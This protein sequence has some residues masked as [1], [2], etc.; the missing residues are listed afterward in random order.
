MTERSLSSKSFD[1]SGNDLD[2]L[3]NLFSVPM[4]SHCQRVAICSAII[5]GHVDKPLYPSGV[6]TREK[7]EVLLHL[8]GTCHD[9]GKLLFP[10][11][12]PNAADYLQHPVMG[13][14]LLEKYKDKLFSSEEQALMVIEIVRCHHEKPDGSGFPS[15]LCLRD[16]PLT[17]G[18]CAAADFLDHIAYPLENFAEYSGAVLKKIKKRTNKGFSENIGV[19]VG[20]AWP[21]L[22]AQYSHW[23]ERLRP[24]RR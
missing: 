2:E 16:I 21:Q 9:V 10:T 5:G 20:K 19:L 3:I 15:G 17:A 13:A 18:I 14:Q 22:V 11:I 1:F 8:G 24:R 6:S 4:H 12:G 7:F 23:N